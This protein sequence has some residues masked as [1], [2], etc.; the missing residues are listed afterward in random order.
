[1]VEGKN[2]TIPWKHKLIVLVGI[3]IHLP[4]IS[5]FFDNI[6]VMNLSP[7][8]QVCK[9]IFIFYSNFWFKA[10]FH[11]DCEKLSISSLWGSPPSLLWSVKVLRPAKALRRM[12]RVEYSVL[13]HHSGQVAR[14]VYDILLTGLLVFAASVGTLW[15]VLSAQTA[16]CPRG[17]QK[18]N[19]S[20]LSIP[21]TMG[22]PLFFSS[23]W[24]NLFIAVKHS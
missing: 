2:K 24:K 19:T 6:M 5:V 15:M 1:M 14:E 4:K 18:Q 22:F 21:I 12:W 20:P 17:Y 13:N 8:F 7:Q 10:P 9:Q 3:Y 23:E 11:W 16:P